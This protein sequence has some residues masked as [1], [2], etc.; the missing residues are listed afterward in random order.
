MSSDELIR[1]L[2]KVYIE[3]LHTN[4]LPAPSCGLSFWYLL[5]YV[6]EAL[7]VRS[8]K[9]RTSMYCFVLLIGKRIC[10]VNVTR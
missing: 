3:L 8:S 7:A 6:I 10:K 5:H 4:P 1:T 9:L 2:H